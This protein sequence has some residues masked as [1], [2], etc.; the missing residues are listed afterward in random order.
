MDYAI[1]F[2]NTAILSGTDSGYTLT[3]DELILGCAE[4]TNWTGF[5][6]HYQ[7]AAFFQGA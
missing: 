6:G 1:Y 5:A 3:M 2:D 7:D 4:S